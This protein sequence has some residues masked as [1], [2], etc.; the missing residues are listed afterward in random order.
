MV[1]TGPPNPLGGSQSVP[2]SLLRT[3]SGVMGGQGGSMPSPGGFPSMVSPRTMFGNMNML[4]NAPN[5]SHQSFANGGPNAGLAG[6]GSSQRGPVDNGAETDPLSG[7]GNGM[8]FSAPSTSFMSSA[9]VTNPDSSRVQGQQFP[10]PS[11][12]HM[13]IDQQ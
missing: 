4:G 10:N 13:L 2:S 9:M 1:P 12:N 8:G 5:V 6:P 11:G 3:N 7:V